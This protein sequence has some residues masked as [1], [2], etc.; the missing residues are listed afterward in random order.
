MKLT[1]GFIAGFITGL[2]IYRAPLVPVFRDQP[3]TPADWKPK[4]RNWKNGIEVI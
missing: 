4:M 3:P 2:A 1:L